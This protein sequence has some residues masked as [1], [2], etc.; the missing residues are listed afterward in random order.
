M[1]Y[2]RK[3]GLNVPFSAL[4]GLVALACIDFSEKWKHIGCAGVKYNV[5]YKQANLNFGFEFRLSSWVGLKYN[6]YL[7]DYKQ[8]SYAEA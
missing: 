3:T 8:A 2:M 4:Q 7:I 5:K 6:V 1:A